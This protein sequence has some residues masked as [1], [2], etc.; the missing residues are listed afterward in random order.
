MEELSLYNGESI[1]DVNMDYWTQIA[2]PFNRPTTS[3]EPLIFFCDNLAIN[4]EAASTNRRQQS[5]LEFYNLSLLSRAN[6]IRTFYSFDFNLIYI[7]RSG[8]IYI[9]KWSIMLSV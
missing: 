6:P 3:T 8:N 2:S 4:T 7:C 9:C 5:N 1:F